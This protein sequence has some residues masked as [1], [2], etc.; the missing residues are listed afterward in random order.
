MAYF[1]RLRTADELSQGPRVG[2]TAG[3]V[4]GNA[5]ARNRIKRRMREAV[6]LHLHLLHASVPAIDLVLHPRKSVL[7][8]DFSALEREIAKVFTQAARLAVDPGARSAPRP[9]P[10]PT[11]ELP[12]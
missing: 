8:L 7:T 4:L 3:R 9:S 2:L 11:S 10:K 12:S 6:R 1:F 5:V